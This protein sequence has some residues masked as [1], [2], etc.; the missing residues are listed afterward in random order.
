VIARGRISFVCGKLTDCSMP[1]SLDELNSDV[2][3]LIF[4]MICHNEW[5]SIDRRALLPLSLVSKR[6]RLR[7]LPWI[8]H[9]I[10]WRPIHAGAKFLS[11]SLLGYV[12]RVRLTDH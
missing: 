2:L 6:I 5:D 4:R 7:S 12:R 1:A 3:D 9:D 11:N 8:L 10:Y